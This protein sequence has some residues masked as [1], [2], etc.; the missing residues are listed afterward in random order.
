MLLEKVILNLD[1]THY[2]DSQSVRIICEEELLS[3]ALIHLLATLFEEKQDLPTSTCPS[4]LCGLFN[5]MNRSKFK[6][7]CEDL[8]SL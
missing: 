8:M 2:P 1:L 6:G 4:I 7:T 5:M 3:S